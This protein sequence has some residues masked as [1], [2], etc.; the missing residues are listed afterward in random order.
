MGTVS[1]TLENIVC[2]FETAD[3]YDVRLDKNYVVWGSPQA[4]GVSANILDYEG[5]YPSL[6][7]PG[8]TGYVPSELTTLMGD[9]LKVDARTPLNATVPANYLNSSYSYVGFGAQLGRNIEPINYDAN[10]LNSFFFAEVISGS[11]IYLGPTSLQIAP[12]VGGLLVR[13]R[14]ISDANVVTYHGTPALTIGGTVY[15]NRPTPVAGDKI[16]LY[17]GT[18]DDLSDTES[19][20]AIGF[21]NSAVHVERF[22]GALPTGYSI[23]TNQ[24]A[25]VTYESLTGYHLMWT[26]TLP[27]LGTT[28]L[29]MTGAYCTFDASNNKA[30]V[31]LPFDNI[32]AGAQIPETWLTALSLAPRLVKVIK[33]QLNDF[34]VDKDD[35]LIF[36][37]KHMTAIPFYSTNSAL[38][39][40]T[41]CT[42]R[43]M[44]G[45]SIHPTSTQYTD[46]TDAFS[47]FVGHPF[48]VAGDK[49]DYFPQ[50]VYFGYRSFVSVNYS[51]K[52]VVA[53]VT[54]S[55][56]DQRRIQTY[57]KTGGVNTKGQLNIKLGGPFGLTTQLEGYVTDVLSR[58]WMMDVDQWNVGHTQA[59]G[60]T[61]GF[62]KVSCSQFHTVALDMDGWVSAWGSN[63]A[64]NPAATRRK[65]W[66][67]YTDSNHGNTSRYARPPVYPDPNHLVSGWFTNFVDQNRVVTD[68]GT[69]TINRSVSESTNA[70]PLDLTLNGGNYDFLY[71]SDPSPP[72]IT[73]AN[74]DTNAFVF[75][76]PLK[77]TLADNTS[78]LYV[79]QKVGGPGIQIGLENI[80]GEYKIFISNSYVP[81]VKLYSKPLAAAPSLMYLGFD[82]NTEDIPLITSAIKVDGTYVKWEGTDDYISDSIATMSY[83]R[84]LSYIGTFT[85]APT[86]DTLQRMYKPATALS[87][88][89]A[90]DDF[91]SG[92]YLDEPVDIDKVRGTNVTRQTPSEAPAYFS[93]GIGSRKVINN[94]LA[95]DLPN[96][97]LLDLVGPKKNYLTLV[98]R[99]YK[100][101]V[102]VVPTTPV[103]TSPNPVPTPASVRLEG[104]NFRIFLGNIVAE[105][106]DVVLDY[107]YNY[108]SSSKS[109]VDSNKL[110]W[111]TVVFPGEAL[112]NS[113]FSFSPTEVFIYRALYN[114]VP[115]NNYTTV[116]KFQTL[117][118]TTGYVGDGNIDAK[119]LVQ[120][121]YD[122]LVDDP[123][124]QMVCYDSASGRVL[125]QSYIPGANVGG[126]LKSIALGGM[127]TAVI[128]S[129]NQFVSWGWNRYE[130][131]SK[132]KNLTPYGPIKISSSNEW[133]LVLSGVGVRL[134]TSL[135]HFDQLTVPPNLGSGTSD[136]STSYFFAAA[137]SFTSQVICWGYEGF[138]PEV[139]GTLGACSKVACGESHVLVLKQD[140][141]VACFGN[142][143]YGQCDIP[144]AVANGTVTHIAC[145]PNMSVARL[146]TGVVYWWGA[147]LG[148]SN[149]GNTVY[150]CDET[151]GTNQ[152]FIFVVKSSDK[153][154]YCWPDD[155]GDFYDLVANRP[156]NA[157]SF[158]KLGQGIAA[159]HMCAATDTTTYAWGTR[160]SDGDHGA[161]SYVP[162][163]ASKL[164]VGC[165]P[166]SFILV[167]PY[168]HVVVST[169]LGTDI[170]LE[171][172]IMPPIIRAKSEELIYS[173][174]EI[175]GLG[176]KH[177]IAI[178]GGDKCWFAIYANNY[179]DTQGT[180]IAWAAD[181][182][183]NITTVPTG[184]TY[185]QVSSRNRHA[186][187]LKSDGT[188]VCW[189]LNTSG[190]TTIPACIGTCTKVVCGDTFTTAIKTNGLLAIWGN[191]NGVPAIIPSPHINI[192]F[193]D[194]SCGLDHVVG[195]AAANYTEASFVVEA[196]DVLAFGDNTRG[197]CNIPG[198][199][200]TSANKGIKCKAVAGG[201][202][203]AYSLPTDGFTLKNISS[204]TPAAIV[205]VAGRL[206]ET[207]GFER[208]SIVTTDYID[209]YLIKYSNSVCSGI[210]PSEHPFVVVYPTR[211]F[212]PPTYSILNLTG[213]SKAN[214]ISNATD[215]P[216][217]YKRNGTKK[218]KLITAGRYAQHVWSRA[219]HPFGAGYTAI[220]DKDTNFIQ[221]VGGDAMP[222]NCNVLTYSPPIEKSH[223]YNVPTNQLTDAN[224]IQIGT[225]RGNMFVLTGVG[226][227]VQWGY[228]DSTT[229]YT[230]NSSVTVRQY[231]DVPATAIDDKIP[232]LPYPS[233]AFALAYVSGAPGISDSW[234]VN[235]NLDRYVDGVKTNI[236]TL[237]ATGNTDSYSI[238]MPVHFAETF[239]AVDTWPSNST[240][241]DSQY[242]LSIDPSGV[243]CDVNTASLFGM[244]LDSKSATGPILKDANN[245]SAN[246][247]EVADFM[248]ATVEDTTLA[249]NLLTVASNALTVNTVTEALAGV[250]FT[251]NELVVNRSYVRNKYGSSA[252]VESVPAGGL[253]GLLAGRV[254]YI[255]PV[256]PA[257]MPNNTN[258]VAWY[259]S[260]SLP[261]V[262]AEIS[263]WTN[264]AAATGAIS[265]LSQ[266]LNNLSP[267]VV[268]F[269][270]NYKG[271]QF[272]SDISAID[273]LSSS[274]PN[275]SETEFTYFVVYNKTTSTTDHLDFGKLYSPTGGASRGVQGIGWIAGRPTLYTRGSNRYRATDAS[276]ITGNGIL[277][278]YYRGSSDYGLRRN[279]TAVPLNA[280]ETN[281]N[282]SSTLPLGYHLE[283]R[284]V[285]SNHDTNDVCA[286][287]VAFNGSLTDIQIQQVEGYLAHKLE[288]NSFLPDGHPYK[289]SA[290]TEEKLD[291]ITPA[292]PPPNI[293]LKE[294]NRLTSNTGQAQTWVGMFEVGLN[295]IAQR[296]TPGGNVYHDISPVV[297]EFGIKINQT[298]SMLTIPLI[299]K[300][301]SIA[302][303]LNVDS[304][305]KYMNGKVFGKFEIASVNLFVGLVIGQATAEFKLRTTPALLSRYL[306]LN[307]TPVNCR[308]QEF[309]GADCGQYGCLGVSPY[310]PDLTVLKESYYGNITTKLVIPAVTMNKLVGLK[311][312]VVRFVLNTPIAD[313]NVFRS[314]SGSVTCVLRTSAKLNNATVY[315]EPVTIS[316]RLKLNTC[317]ASFAFLNLPQQK[318]FV[319]PTPEVTTGD[320]GVISSEA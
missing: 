222:V 20:R 142:N 171:Y 124:T 230:L 159:S 261:A 161:P 139:P 24:A 240:R 184:T 149:N 258:L 303:E 145:T 140:N 218:A 165:N 250:S 156:T 82:E 205:A 86:Q 152:V 172:D 62:D 235:V 64:I 97:H 160:Y 115:T 104:N 316:A 195:T 43:I 175:T 260:E 262:A 263:T 41:S 272:D 39:P 89:V 61:Y 311:G 56:A 174:A 83:S 151:L 50:N 296:T 217:A 46:D 155:I 53:T 10:N 130:Q 243:S 15:F 306:N 71:P 23:V 248:I 169:K 178:A 213:Y 196:G 132:L 190:Q 9:I 280:F 212:N 210:L 118:S 293:I 214:L 29:C 98:T 242:I 289:A 298:L 186:A 309:G 108:S 141:K 207:G 203:T 276:V 99:T 106:G 35:P 38:P 308:L 189:G 295:H 304:T 314:M 125:P 47:F 269:K 11:S 114:L 317:V 271:A 206:L 150:P 228:Q 81:L 88:M 157:N 123:L 291:V 153:K 225:F 209:G 13:V 259:K 220:V 192:T 167:G 134:I 102:V 30:K 268:P 8:E 96:L 143:N 168:K 34:V 237:T 7:W 282:I 26:G 275:A 166:N 25:A 94:T 312:P 278:G 92:L 315:L 28:T 51:Y 72:D 320:G 256:T 103:Y 127:H 234:Y 3:V 60:L 219:D 285:L 176:L 126:G 109:G 281:A 137:V 249:T 128:N 55:T 254:P 173:S 170:D 73:Y 223:L 246:M 265:P 267:A 22:V 148:I 110:V 1:T 199:S 120:T 105:V 80:G 90:G 5:Y 12:L 77:F 216:I 93:L 44:Y 48:I 299:A 188:V 121:P 286:E 232:T 179:A 69:F 247:S 119:P 264:S 79:Q 198:F 208:E 290:P 59:P 310:P 117:H 164:G 200:Y 91:F 147:A 4:Y 154:I 181:T 318:Y 274:N 221:M 32:Y 42:A 66:T 45:L 111:P 40:V 273:F 57:I 279:G 49:I 2:S 288:L 162:T 63:S 231:I 54:D 187:A 136:I 229:N 144:S 244:N 107:L 67:P 135:K 85:P 236:R 16:N 238:S 257:T 112:F 177:A 6:N 292:V 255:T 215:I 180:L 202:F 146:S 163:T 113:P 74:F 14:T 313:L 65:L 251:S 185:T 87:K 204:A 307:T 253:G 21:T 300:F 95:Q 319:K 158:W 101:C 75:F 226:A 68:F 287:V 70:T 133:T 270:I 36:P 245:M 224:I 197:Q 33:H 76:N 239:L 297:A 302:A 18:E 233:L 58:S 305:I 78:E 191:I 84:S 31:Y 138:V 201:G 19:I 129:A 52:Y 241:L 37:I 183:N 283:A 252:I 116:D 194:I 182:T 193:N 27:S 277:C 294:T 131:R 227:V 266:P 301:N 122:P 17:A 284:V 100:E 211:L